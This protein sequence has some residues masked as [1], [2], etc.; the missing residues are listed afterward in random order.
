[1]SFYQNPFSPTDADRHAL[2][3][4]LVARDTRAFVAQDWGQVAGDFVE[5]G[6]MG[7]N[8]RF[9]SNPDSWQLTFPELSAYRDDWLKQGREFAAVA[10]DED[11]ERAMYEATTLRDIEIV[12]DSAL[13]HK[14]FD[15]SIRKQDGSTDTL[16]WQ[17]LYRCRK[18]DGSWKIA[19]F[20]GYLPHPMGHSVEQSS[21]AKVLPTNASQ[22][23]TAGPYSPV[24]LVN[25]GQ[26]VV[27]SGQAALDKDGNIVGQT[28]EEQTQLTLENC[29]WQL[30]SAGCSLRDVFKVNVYLKDLDDWAKMNQLYKT[31]FSEPYPVRT[32]VQT[33]LLMTLL[34][35][36]EMWAVKK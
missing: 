5:S 31:F 19:G 17:T 35:E 30:E 33:G 14:K 22:H 2:W 1:M 25:P 9:R 28:V 6:F 27:V 34:V 21:P 24:L 26:L 18:V 36:V 13:L 10:W 23:T 12:G 8:A 29:Q 15:G 16:N 3:E 4:M 20:V 7:I 11:P 32:A